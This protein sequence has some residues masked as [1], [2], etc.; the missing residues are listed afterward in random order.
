MEDIFEGRSEEVNPPLISQPEFK[1]KGKPGEISD[2]KVNFRRSE[3][4]GESS[5]V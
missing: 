5:S 2:A 3:Y 1:Y 4:F